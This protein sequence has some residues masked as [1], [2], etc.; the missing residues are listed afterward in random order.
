MSIMRTVEMRSLDPEDLSAYFRE[1]GAQEQDRGYFLGEGWS[2]RVT[3]GETVELGTLRLERLF[4]SIEAEE[5]LFGPF[6]DRF[7][8]RFLRCGG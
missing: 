3:P 4:V 5:E 6:M 8:A 1:L 7:N 2:A